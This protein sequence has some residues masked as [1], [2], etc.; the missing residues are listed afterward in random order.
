M[1]PKPVVRPAVTIEA[2]AM[3]VMLSMVCPLVIHVGRGAAAW[4]AR[5]SRGGDVDRGQDAEDV[6]L[7]HA[8]EQAEHVMTIGKMNGVIVSRMRDDHRAAHHVAEQADGQRQRAREL[9]DDIER[10]HDERRLDVGLQVAAQPLLLDAEERHG[11]EYAQRERRGGRERAGRRLVA[12][13][14]GAEI[15][16]GDEQK[17]RAEKAEI[18]LRLRQADLLDLLLDA[19]DDDLQQVLPAGD[20]SAPWTACG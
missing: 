10:Q 7:H 18:L 11:H 19:G 4:L 15:G 2:T 6:G 9:A 1:L 3:M 20:A 17:E 8:G 16:R 12:G 5:A 14:D 13:N